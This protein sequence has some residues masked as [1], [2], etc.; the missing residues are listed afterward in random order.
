MKTYREYR[1]MGV[2]A[3][4]ALQW[5]KQHTEP[6]DWQDDRVQWEQDGFTIRVY[7]EEDHDPDFSILGKYTDKWSPDVINCRHYNT[8]CDYAYFKPTISETAHYQALRA[9]KY[10]KTQ[11]R[12][13]ARTY[14]R[15]DFDRIQGYNIGEWSMVGVVVSVFKN[16]VHLAT[17][18]L[19]GIE[20][21]AD[22]DYF[23]QVAR[24]CAADALREATTV[25]AT[26]CMRSQ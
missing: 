16:G 18:A 5:A 2:A 10:G 17:D 11:A 6:L 8:R 12:Q 20:S 26:L 9:M 24:E 21:D 3:R 1:A 15:R 23:T 7:I 4:V 19:W 13:L 22:H 25:L 14:V